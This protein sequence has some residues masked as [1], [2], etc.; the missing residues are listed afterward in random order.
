MLQISYD[1]SG[2]YL[3]APF[4]FAVEVNG[5]ESSRS[6]VRTGY[7]TLKNAEGL[8]RLGKILKSEG[9]WTYE[10]S[11]VGGSIYF[12]GPAGPKNY[13]MVFDDVPRDYLHGPF[14][15]SA[16]GPGYIKVSPD[17]MPGFDW[18]VNGPG[19]A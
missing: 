19:C 11:A 13:R 15:S 10:S 12:H 16:T 5:T 3:N 18:S 2:S 8:G 1:V 9:Y 17:S 6:L 4:S 14:C 7:W